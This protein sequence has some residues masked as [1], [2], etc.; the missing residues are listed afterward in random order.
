M[1]VKF[2]LLMIF[3]WL[4][5]RIYQTL[6]VKKQRKVTLEKSQDMVSCEKCGIHIPVNEATKLNNKFY[7]SPDHADSEE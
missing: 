1:V 7:C 4:G 5:F 3:V 6:Q 2:I